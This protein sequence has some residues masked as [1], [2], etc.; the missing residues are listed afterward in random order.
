MKQLFTL[1]A[2]Q[3]L[4]VWQNARCSFLGASNPTT[5]GVV[6]VDATEC[7]TIHDSKTML[8]SVDEI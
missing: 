1:P 7:P 4:C 8:Y 5:C 6:N 2:K 3:V